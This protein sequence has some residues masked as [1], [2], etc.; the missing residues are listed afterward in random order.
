M[1]RRDLYAGLEVDVDVDDVSLRRAYKRLISQYD[2]DTN[3]GDSRALERFERVRAAYEVL[4]DHDRRA[5]Y[6]EFG[7]ASLA[8]G[9]DPDT[10]REEIAREQAAAQRR[11]KAALVMP[12]ALQFQDGRPDWQLRLSIGPR[13][14]RA[15]GL[16]RLPVTRPEPCPRCSGSG[17]R[18]APCKSCKGTRELAGQRVELCE[19]CRGVGLLAEQHD[20]KSCRGTGVR[21]QRCKSCQGAGRVVRRSDCPSCHGRGLLV[22]PFVEPCPDCRASGLAPCGRCEG[23]G[24]VPKA[25]RLSLRVPKGVAPDLEYRYAGAGFS[26]RGGVPTDLYV[27]FVLLAKAPRRTGT[28][29]RRW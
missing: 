20:C 2:P 23:S 14:A 16:L 19:P 11:A 12:T 28:S 27:R 9:F 18:R 26:S 29:R 4:K 13:L 17:R 8:A 1:G 24:Q 3:P 7:E 21:R 25:R 5:L 22:T 10:A 6:D 15:G